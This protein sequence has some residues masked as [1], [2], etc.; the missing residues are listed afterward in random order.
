MTR[1]EPHFLDEIRSRIRITEVVA[2]HVIWDKKKSQ[3]AKGD[4]WAC[5]PFHGEKS[6]SFH[7]E[8]KRGIY[9]CFSCGA[10]GDHF[11]FLVEIA[12]LSFPKAVEELAREAGVEMPDDHRR[13]D[14]SPEERAQW[15]AKQEERR[16]AHAAAQ[17]QS[18]IDEQEDRAERTENAATVWKETLLLSGSL[19]DKYFSE[20]RGLPPV[21]EWPWNPEMTLRF[22]P[23]LYH[24]KS[25]KFYPAIVCRVVDSF[26]VGCGIWRIYLAPDGSG[27]APEDETKLGLGPTAGGAVRLGG[28]GPNLGIGEGVETCLSA[29]FLNGCHKP[30]WAGLSTSGVTGFEIPSFVKRLEIFPDGD[31]AKARETADGKFAMSDRPGMA[32]AKGLEA[33]AVPILGRENVSI[34]PEPGLKQDYNDLYIH[35]KSK[36]LL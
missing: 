36:G 12:G 27:K 23:R 19:G 16:K 25:K 31:R 32:A 26:G 9:K 13:R 4:M 2:R 15:E 8:D 20:A 29:W 5:C 35:M 14:Q 30:V 33:E 11:R 6:P 7:A 10:S 21:S 22:H 17:A 1:F 34:A 24:A 28:D 3:P 18:L